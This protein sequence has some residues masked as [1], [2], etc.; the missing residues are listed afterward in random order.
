MLVALVGPTGAG[1][2]T[3][4]HMLVHNWNYSVFRIVT[5]RP[6]RGR[7]IDRIS[8]SASDFARLKRSG[9]FL[10]VNSAF[11][12]RYGI[13]RHLLDSLPSIQP[14]YLMDPALDDLD[15]ISKLQGHKILFL[16]LPPT[17][18]ELERRLLEKGRAARLSEARDQYD[19]CK[20]AI[21]NGLPELTTC[22]IVINESAEES[23]NK[24]YMDID[25]VQDE[26]L[27]KAA[28]A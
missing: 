9:A 7:E 26:L 14:T 13:P 4:T 25:A 6:Q 16:I 3:I 22:R 28:Y 20:A 11:G 5:T 21:A 15:K 8:V 10:W 23:A 1:K 18:D 12:Y 24:I 27:R 19:R 17:W 2:S